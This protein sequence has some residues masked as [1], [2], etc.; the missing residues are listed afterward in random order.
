MGGT[1]AG[2]IA[3]PNALGG[4]GGAETRALAAAD[5]PAHQH[6]MNHGHADGTSDG[7]NTDHA[8]YV[9]VQ[10]GGQSVDHWH[11][12]QDQTYPLFVVQSFAPGGS[13]LVSQNNGIVGPENRDRT[14]GVNTDHSHGVNGW[15]GGQNVSHAHTTHTPAFNGNTG[16]VGGGAGINTM[17]PYIL[18]NKII[19]T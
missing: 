17:P 14:G 7:A 4:V 13:G 12:T 10:S 11:G 19:R 1:D 9:S 16:S 6:T 8:H 3:A 5:L 18:V 15:S 2:R